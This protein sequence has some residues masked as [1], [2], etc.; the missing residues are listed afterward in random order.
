METIQ[1]KAHNIRQ[2]AIL[3]TNDNNL[4]STYKTVMTV[5][6]RPVSLES[7]EAA[8]IN[9][10]DTVIV[11]GNNRGGILRASAYRN[12][13]NGASGGTSR[14][15]YLLFASFVTVLALVMFGGYGAEFM[16]GVSPEDMWIVFTGVGLVIVVIGLLW[17]GAIQSLKAHAAVK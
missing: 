7:D 9:E 10:G 16:R 2:H 4:E 14:L 5:D 3:I 13:T 1:G 6:G 11:A 15:K 8:V 12:M 17:Y